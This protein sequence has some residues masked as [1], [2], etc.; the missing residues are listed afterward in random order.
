[1][2]NWEDFGLLKCGKNIWY[3]QHVEHIFTML[4]G[5]FHIDNL[6]VALGGMSPAGQ[7]KWSFSSQPRWDTSGVLGSVLGSPIWETYWRQSQQRATNTL[8]LE[9]LSHEERLR[10]LVLFSLGKR[11]LKESSPMCESIWRDC[12]KETGSIH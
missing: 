12:V 8:G 11:K 2:E 7:S 4:K 5:A 10:E 9:H 3:L 6:T 1:M